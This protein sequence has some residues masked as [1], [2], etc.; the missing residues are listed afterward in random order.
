MTPMDADSAA[1]GEVAGVDR[2]NAEAGAD[3]DTIF[4]MLPEVEGWWTETVWT[5]SECVSWR[6]FHAE[7]AENLRRGTGTTARHVRGP[8][9]GS[10]E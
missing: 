10:V 6:S 7:A 1:S 9:H 5:G 3:A 8:E 4:D 2:L